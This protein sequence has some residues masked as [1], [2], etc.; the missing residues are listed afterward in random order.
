MLPPV[1]EISP[2]AQNFEYDYTIWIVGSALNYSALSRRSRLC[3]N[4]AFA[5]SLEKPWIERKYIV[6]GLMKH[7]VHEVYYSGNKLF[8][9]K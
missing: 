9:H 1:E 2:L 8:L 5:E 4:S 3:V 6:W 7:L